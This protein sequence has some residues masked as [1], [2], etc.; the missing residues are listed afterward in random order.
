MKKPA[1]ISLL[2]LIVLLISSFFIKLSSLPIRIWDEARL[3]NN[4][5]EMYLNGNWIVTYYDGSP[6]SYNTKPP[7]LIWLQVMNMHLLGL[8]EAA[9]RIPSALASVFT[10]ILVWWFLKRRLQNHWT[11]FLAGSVFATTFAYVYIHAGRTGDYDALLTL[12]TTIYCISI[13]FFLTE[14]RPKWLYL[15]WI[16][17]TLAALTKGVAAL[18]FLPGLFFFILSQKSFSAFLF[19]KHFYIGIAGFVFLI[20]GYYWLR[21]QYN[22]GYLEAVWENELGGRYATTLEGHDHP[23]SYYYIGMKQ[24]RNTFWFYFILPAFLAGF[25]I[26]NRETRKLSLFN[27]LMILPYFL[28]ISNAQTKLEWYDIPLYPFLSIQIGILLYFIWQWINKFIYQKQLKAF[29]AIIAFLLVFFFPFRQCWNFIHYFK[30]NAWDIAP[31]Q[32]GY[33]LQNAIRQNRDLR[34]YY[35]CYTD[36]H[37]QIKFYIEALRHQGVKVDLHHTLDYVPPG[38]KLV[39]SQK[40]VTDSLQ[41]GFIVQKLEEAFGCTV[42]LVQ[43]RL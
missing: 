7:L 43:R 25:F 9:V 27:L 42:Y 11:G 34:D 39:V 17:L 8:N 29:A 10:G 1:V 19:N 32:Q 13:Y 20:G 4:A 2:L 14:K 36:Y 18:L 22:P 23:F 30:E 5:L 21:E 16:F 41:K 37:G 6:D 26:R 38:K 33:F 31:H 24:W 15:F 40:S 28:I 3:A 35:F 12:F